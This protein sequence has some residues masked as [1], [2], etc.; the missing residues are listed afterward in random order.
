MNSFHE[1]WDFWVSVGKIAPILTAL[2]AFGAATI[3]WFAL[4]A[5]KKLAGHK[6]ALDFFLKS[7]M[8]HQMVDIYEKYDIALQALESASDGEV[9]KKSNPEEY[10]QVRR[11]LNIV[12]LMALGVRKKAM[13]QDVCR[14]FW[15]NIVTRAASKGKKIID[16]VQLQP[17]SELTYQEIVNLG[18]SWIAQAK[19]DAPQVLRDVKLVWWV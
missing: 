10:K 9:F 13:D 15:Y 19:R 17:G 12:E 8:D 7:E 2:I 6:A 1:S 11:F 3:A 18:E 5:Q 4:R 14:D 16:H